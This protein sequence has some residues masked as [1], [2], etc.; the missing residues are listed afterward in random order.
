[1]WYSYLTYFN[2]DRTGTQRNWRKCIFYWQAYS[3]SCFLTDPLLLC[4]WVSI[5]FELSF[6]PKILLHVSTLLFLFIDLYVCNYASSYFWTTHESSYV[7]VGVAGQ[8]MKSSAMVSLMQG[9]HEGARYKF[10]VGYFSAQGINYHRQWYCDCKIC[11]CG[12]MEVLG[13]HFMIC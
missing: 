4:R 13:E 2:F 6:L 1:M 12:F 10:S 8:W 9:E 5:T 3:W 7:V 11:T